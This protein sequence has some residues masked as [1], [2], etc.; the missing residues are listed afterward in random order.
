MRCVESERD[1]S[2][3]S[4]RW[5]VT[6]GRVMA[7]SLL[8]L[9]GCKAISTTTTVEPNGSLERHIVLQ[10]DSQ[11]LTATGYPL[12]AVSDVEWSYQ[13]NRG[14]PETEEAEETWLHEF[15][16]RFRSA[17]DLDSEIARLTSEGPHLKHRVEIRKRYRWFTTYLVFREVFDQMF[18]YNHIPLSDFLTEEE[19]E[20]LRGDDAPDEISDR[21]EEWLMRNV[22]EDLYLRLLETAGEQ[23]AIPPSLEAFRTHKE[24]LFQALMETFEEIGFEDIGEPTLETTGKVMEVEDVNH[25]RPAVEAF[26]AGFQE[27][28]AVS[29]LAGGESYDNTVVMPGLLVGTNAA[30]V[31]G[32]RVTW[33]FEAGDL[34]F[35]PIDMWVES[36]V[37]NRTAIWLAMIVAALLVAV[38]VGGVVR[39]RRAV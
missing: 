39:R 24:E 12:P 30:E 9:G 26:E 19:L 20:V 1:R 22:Y 25:L 18:P 38:L 36:R 14:Q 31:V 5:P 21:A 6:S 29:D 11:E 32:N 15:R 34:D 33:K 16:R 2:S 10:S 35:G 13:V 37:T 7:A 3:G 28:A 23:E 4:I 17:G 27:Y 8:L